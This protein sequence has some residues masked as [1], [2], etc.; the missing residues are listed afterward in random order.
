MRYAILLVVLFSGIMSSAQFE[1]GELKYTGLGSYV[2]PAFHLL[3][4]GTMIASRE[5]H[6]GHEMCGSKKYGGTKMALQ[7]F[8]RDGNLLWQ[9]CYTSGSQ[10]IVRIMPYGKGRLACL[11]YNNREVPGKGR[12]M[13]FWVLIIDEDG[14]ELED[15]LVEGMRDHQQTVLCASV[16]PDGGFI[17]AGK[18]TV[19]SKL[20][21]EEIEVDMYVIKAN[22]KGELEWEKNINNAYWDRISSIVPSK[23]G[24][25]IAGGWCQFKGDK[26]EQ[27]A[28]TARIVKFDKNGEILWQKQYGTGHYDY[29]SG[30]IEKENGDIVFIGRETGM[31]DIR[32]GNCG[33]QG[34][35]IA[36][37]DKTGRLKWENFM[38]NRSS[39]TSSYTPSAALLALDNG[40]YMVGGGHINPDFSSKLWLAEFDEK[41]GLVYEKNLGEL[42]CHGVYYIVPS[43]GGYLAAGWNRGINTFNHE[44][45]KF[46]IEVFET[47]TMEVNL[48]KD[49]D[50]NVPD[51]VVLDTSLSQ[52]IAY[53]KQGEEAAPHLFV[54]VHKI[55]E[56]QIHVYPNPAH[57]YIN[58]ELGQTHKRMSVEVYDVEGKL[59]LQSQ[60]EDTGFMALQIGALKKGT[61]LIMLQADEEM[62][63][64]KFVKQ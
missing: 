4:D 50:K 33:S 40:G 48:G 35:W 45:K 29:I 41:G 28:G 25:Y 5:Y 46:G 34:F 49:A 32:H 63:R 15:F 19:P 58:I 18:I 36:G 10:K 9:K 54:Q 37:L 55:A 17:G 1:L 12:D 26:Q 51:S 59:V 53:Q 60:V 42:V 24:G 7:R 47:W 30:L 27:K 3:D 43:N 22:K 64:L 14:N 31:A 39:G 44:T 23:D 38:M 20:P 62:K 6:G 57:E 2:M 52:T 56:E 16:T 13:R 21:G 61:Y 11:G 8:D